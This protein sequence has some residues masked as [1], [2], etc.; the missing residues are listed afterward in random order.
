MALTA[1][2]RLA[3]SNECVLIIENRGAAPKETDPGGE[4]T[5]DCVPHFFFFFSWHSNVLPSPPPAD[6]LG[7][8]DLRHSVLRNR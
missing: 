4:S 1:L 5:G 7:A 3:T 8:G 2:V 6:E